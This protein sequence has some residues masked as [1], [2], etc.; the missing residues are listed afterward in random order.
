MQSFIVLAF[1]VSEL[2]GGHCDPPVLNVTKAKST[3]VLLRLSGVITL[4][5][6]KAVILEFCD[7]THRRNLLHCKCHWIL[8]SVQ[9]GEGCF[10]PPSH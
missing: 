7:H 9:G 1:L 2:A 3:L 10:P 5:L 6:G 4:Y 8:P